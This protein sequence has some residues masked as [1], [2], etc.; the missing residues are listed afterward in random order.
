MYVYTSLQA[1]G[2]SE[3]LKLR[4]DGSS[5]KDGSNAGDN[6]K[7]DNNYE[8]RA[9][10]IEGVGSTSSQESTE[11]IATLFSKFGKGI[12]TASSSAA[13]ALKPVKETKIMDVTKKGYDIAKE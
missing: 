3:N 1:K 10:I 13:A 8:P 4:Y 11:T 2:L 9:E 12:S 6:V 7:F 5:K